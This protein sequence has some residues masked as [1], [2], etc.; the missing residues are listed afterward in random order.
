MHIPAT[1]LLLWG[2]LVSSFSCGGS[3]FADH[4][5]ADRSTISE[6]IDH[7]NATTSLEDQRK[8][9]EDLYRRVSLNGE[10]T[11]ARDIVALRRLLANDSDAVRFW[12]AATLGAIG[13]SAKSAVPELRAAY[14]RSACIRADL[15]S[16]TAIEYALEQLGTGLPE[17]VCGD[18]LPPMSGKAP[19]VQQSK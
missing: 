11:S 13:A 17:V 14:L 7:I 16:V 4:L 5:N 3:A 12:V 2:I 6:E 15:T 10:R 1:R 8:Y 18:G 9:A 19:S